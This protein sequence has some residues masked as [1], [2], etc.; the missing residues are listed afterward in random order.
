[1]AAWVLSLLIFLQP[2]APWRASYEEETA[3]A[4]ATAAEHAEP[5]FPGPDGRARAAALLVAVAY[6]ESRFDPNAVG[7]GGRS[8]GLFQHQRG[9][10]SNF[11]ATVA[12]PRALETMRGSMNACRARP[13]EERLA[14]Y[15]SGRC[16]RGL[17]AS[18][19]RLSLGR[20]LLAGH[21]PP[22]PIPTPPSP[23]E[24]PRGPTPA[25]SAP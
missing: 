2:D 6:H 4:I 15:A 25:R 5:L 14:A 13:A 19:A 21:P 22:A 7:D 20:A 16:D 18:R 11:A 24:A 10:A 3:R 1:M 8:F 17:A 23:H 9:G 12:A